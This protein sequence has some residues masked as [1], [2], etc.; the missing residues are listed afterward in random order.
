VLEYVNKLKSSPSPTSGYNF[1][2]VAQDSWNA[3][4]NPDECL[5]NSYGFKEIIVVEDYE[6]GNGV[7]G[8]DQ[9]CYLSLVKFLTSS[10][11]RN[12]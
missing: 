8:L 3:M 11:S 6:V 2:L 5:W 7:L 10:I 12:V 4:L 9:D 1:P